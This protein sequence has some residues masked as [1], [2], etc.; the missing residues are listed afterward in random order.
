[1]MLRIAALAAV[2]FLVPALAG[3][4]P[5]ASHKGTGLQ[6]FSARYQ[7]IKDGKPIGAS[8]FT[9][10][11]S[12]DG[13]HYQSIT[14]GTSGLASLL[15]TRVEENT[16]FRLHDAKVELLQH[17]YLVHAAFY[18]RNRSISV[19]WQTGAVRVEDSRDGKATYA[20]VPGLIDKHL[21]SLVLARKLQQ[22]DRL[23]QL[24]VAV[25]DRVRVE[26]FRIAGE[27]RVK[28]PAGTYQATRVDRI[29]DH[30]MSAWYA[31]DIPIPVKL[32]QRGDDNLTL[33]LTEFH[34]RHK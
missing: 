22:N 19:N 23:L 4:T 15:G 7:V 6:P 21:L 34:R 18:E 26:R 13:W 14:K 8:H 25:H 33:L 30:P 24:P 20:A 27:D 31:P 1:M 32:A 29:D 5:P 28:V 17:D 12:N 11:Q 9:L 10:K 2:F 3:Q 16:R